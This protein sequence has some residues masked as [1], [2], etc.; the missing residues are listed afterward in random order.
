MLLSKNFDIL[1]LITESVRNVKTDCRETAF[2]NYDVSFPPQRKTEEAN[3][4][5]SSFARQ[6]QMRFLSINTH[7]KD[8]LPSKLY[9]TLTAHDG[10]PDKRDG[11]WTY[12][13]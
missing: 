3:T 7:S 6:N 11:Q 1:P 8:L 10:V 13:E 12:S 2:Q 5:I 9:A 4:S